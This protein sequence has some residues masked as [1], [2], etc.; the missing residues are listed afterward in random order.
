MVAQTTPGGGLSH[1]PK[2][3]RVGKASSL[4]SARIGGA[5][6]SKSLRF[7]KAIF[8]ASKSLNEQS[9]DSVRLTTESTD[10]R[11]FQEGR[12][13]LY[14]IRGSVLEQGKD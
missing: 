8:F 1:H 11:G 3:Q 9:C 5:S 7:A 14:G 13:V 4:S 10:Q 6:V 12:V 2:D